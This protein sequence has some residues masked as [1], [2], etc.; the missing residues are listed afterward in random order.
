ML[1]AVKATG[2]CDL[3]NRQLRL[4]EQG[5]GAIKPNVEIVSFGGEV[6]IAAKEPL[7]LTFARPL[8][9]EPTPA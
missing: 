5:A 1:G 2:P 3:G 7:K 9:G 6:D 4:G 8:Y